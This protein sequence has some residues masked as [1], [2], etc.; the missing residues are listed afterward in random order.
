MEVSKIKTGLRHQRIEMKK[1]KFDNPGETPTAEEEIA[2]GEFQS[3]LAEPL[4]SVVTFDECAASG[5]QYDEAVETLR[6][7][8]AEKVSGLCIVTDDA[9][10]RISPKKK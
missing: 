6:R 9:A 1:E 4:W 7:L 5:L 3:E 10:A 2:V 8:E